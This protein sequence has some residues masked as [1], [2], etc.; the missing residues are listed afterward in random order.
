MYLHCKHPTGVDI[1]SFLPYL[2]APK[3]RSQPAVLACAVYVQKSRQNLW[4][5]TWWVLPSYGFRSTQTRRSMFSTCRTFSACELRAGY[6]FTTSIR[7]WRAWPVRARMSMSATHTASA[8]LFL[9]NIVTC[10]SACRARVRA[11]PVLT[12]YSFSLKMLSRYLSTRIVYILLFNHTVSS[13]TYFRIYEKLPNI[14]IHAC[15]NITEKTAK[16]D[17]LFTFRPITS[18]VC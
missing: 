16:L 17:F 13:E 1:N 2:Q 14:V 15:S 12:P 8:S 18:F 7:V 11:W 10:F 5:S 6:G 3:P 4:I 9:N